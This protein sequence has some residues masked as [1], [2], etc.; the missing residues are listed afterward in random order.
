M[1]EVKGI[2]PVRKAEIRKKY[3][4]KLEENDESI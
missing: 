1:E 4:E 3:I 2:G